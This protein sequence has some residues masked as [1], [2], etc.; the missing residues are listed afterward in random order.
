MKNSSPSKKCL[1]VMTRFSEM[2]GFFHPISPHRFAILN[3]IQSVLRSSSSTGE[4]PAEVTGSIGR[5]SF[6]WRENKM[7]V[8]SDT[9]KTQIF[10]IYVYI[11]IYTYQNVPFSKGFGRKHMNK[12]VVWQNFP[13]STKDP[14]RKKKHIGKE[15]V[16]MVVVE[17]D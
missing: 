6:F 9:C 12:K 4:D 5:M 16:Q 13:L 11:Q 17:N 7:N 3:H 8:T 1:L 10:I 14:T 15:W 2:E